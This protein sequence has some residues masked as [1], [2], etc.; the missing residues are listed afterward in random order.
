MLAIVVAGALLLRSGA[1]LGGIGEVPGA[2]TIACA[3]VLLGVTLRR[4]PGAAGHALLRTIGIGT[5]LLCL[6]SLV[7]TVA[8][9]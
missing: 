1:G 4:G 8:G 2:V 5:T 6:A 7:L 3:L 9:L